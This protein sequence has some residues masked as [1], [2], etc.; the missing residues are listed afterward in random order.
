MDIASI[1]SDTKQM[2]ESAYEDIEENRMIPEEFED[3]EIPHFTLQLNMPHLP[4]DNNKHNTKKG[5]NHYKEHGKKAFHFKV[6][7]EDVPYFKLLSCHTHCLCLEN[8]YFGKFA[9]FTATLGN[10][11]PMS[12]C[13]RLRR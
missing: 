13:V 7:K 5:Y 8:K 9:K 1:L 6:A 11:A 2:L 12:D 10:N 4:V 3:K